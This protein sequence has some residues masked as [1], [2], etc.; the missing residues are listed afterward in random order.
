MK[1]MLIIFNSLTQ[2][3]YINYDYANISCA[4]Y[5]PIFCYLMLRNPVLDNVM[6]LAIHIN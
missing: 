2:S 4:D 1:Y 6:D 3:Y 5:F